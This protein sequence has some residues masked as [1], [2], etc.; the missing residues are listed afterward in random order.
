MTQ[1]FK[2][3]LLTTGGLVL[4]GTGGDTDKAT[5]ALQQLNKLIAENDGIVEFLIDPKTQEMVKTILK[6]P[7]IKKLMF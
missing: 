7:A 6:N 4:Q 3:E 2:D 5:A 1:G